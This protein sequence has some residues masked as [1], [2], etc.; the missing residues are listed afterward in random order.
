MYRDSPCASL[1][2]TKGSVSVAVLQRFPT[3]NCDICLWAKSTSRHRGGQCSSFCSQF[4]FCFYLLNWNVFFWKTLRG[5]WK[6]IVTLQLPSDCWFVFWTNENE[7]QNTTTFRTNLLKK[8][9]VPNEEMSRDNGQKGSVNKQQ[10]PALK[11]S[12]NFHCQK[13]F[14]SFSHQRA[15]SFTHGLQHYRF[16]GKVNFYRLCELWKMSRQLSTILLIQ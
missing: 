8:E 3:K 16:L 13:L 10:F 9:E 7:K 11:S 1:W 15:I 14:T 2:S 12:P 4:M 6:S 5:S